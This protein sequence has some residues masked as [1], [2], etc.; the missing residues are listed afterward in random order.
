MELE[1]LRLCRKDRQE[2][3]EYAG[4]RMPRRALPLRGGGKQPVV[5]LSYDAIALAHRPLQGLAVDDRDTAAGVVDDSRRLELAGRFGD[6]AARD[7]E[8]V[9][10]ELL[11][12]QELVRL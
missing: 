9:G 12:H 7:T 4:R 1:R 8:H 6:A 11:R 5:L 3:R 10:N 2:I